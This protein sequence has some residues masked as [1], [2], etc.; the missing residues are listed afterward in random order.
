MNV[1]MEMEDAEARELVD[2]SPSLYRS[3]K[4]GLSRKQRLQED[5][6]CTTHALNAVVEISLPHECKVQT[7][8][9]APDPDV[10]PTPSS[11]RSPKPSPH[12]ITG[13]YPHEA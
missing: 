9:V 1:G 6:Y 8:R 11:C 4:D 5:F 13:L 12:L 2:I 7:L 10:D 3:I